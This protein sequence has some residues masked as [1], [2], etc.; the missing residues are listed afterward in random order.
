MSERTFVRGKFV[1]DFKEFISK[2]NVL[3]MAVGVIVGGAFNKIVNSLVADVIMPL[4]GVV[5][6]G[7]DVTEMKYVLNEAVLDAEG[8]IVKAENA[9][10]YGNFLQTVID[11][12]IIAL[13]V[14]VALRVFTSLQRKRKD[15]EAK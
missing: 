8:A 7:V 6:G 9:L 2:G 4:V 1:T 5:M 15:E 12:F 3:D 13:T 14:F 11:F 10:M